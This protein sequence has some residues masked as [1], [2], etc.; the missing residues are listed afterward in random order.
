MRIFDRMRNGWKLG[1]T[2]LKIIQENKSL[3]LFP[4]LSTAALIVVSLTFMGGIFAVLGIDF[5]SDFAVVESGGETLMY[6]F[7]FVFY[8]ITYF[9][10]VFFNVGLVHCARLIFDGEKPT[11]SDGLNYSGSRLGAIFSWAV[12]AATVGV[13]LKVLEDRL[14]WIGQI[15]VGL[16]GIAWSIAT[17]FVVPVIAYENVGPIEAVKRS[18]Q[19]MRQQWGEAVGA[20]FS[21]GAF[22]I[23][24]YLFIFLA[25][26]ALTTI[27][28]ALGIVVGLLSAFLLHTVVGAAKTVF[29]AATYNKMSNRPAGYFDNDTLDSIFIEKR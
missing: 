22:Y 10:I 24:G 23:L 1:M 8:L 13:V 26:A 5:N 28:P 20:N 9:V 18:G 14:G 15:V 3:L 17:F 27:H 19:L 4:I 21:F 16:I 25:A 12:L 11:I 6:L 2:S 7:L 29:I